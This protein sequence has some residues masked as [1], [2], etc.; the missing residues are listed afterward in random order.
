MLFDQDFFDSVDD[1]PILSI[2]RACAMYFDVLS[3]DST[4]FNEYEIESAL[5]TYALVTTIAERHKIVVPIEDASLDGDTQFK[6]NQLTKYLRSVHDFHGGHASYRK[7]DS[8]KRKFEA[9]LGSAF[10]YEFS[11][12]DLDQIQR[13]INELRSEISISN[14]FEANHKSRLLKRLERLQA[15][16][17]KR[18]SDLDGFWGLIGDAGVVAGKFGKD[19]KPIVDRIKEIAD[20]VW[21]TQARTEELP[22]NISRPLLGDDSD[23]E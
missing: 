17:H 16:M 3:D 18:I 23:P 13:L 14:L 9:A 7:I 5:E 1:D 12:G 10:S 6:A 15:E 19:V 2:V 20:I 11:Q 8:Y 4:E 21:R 22:S